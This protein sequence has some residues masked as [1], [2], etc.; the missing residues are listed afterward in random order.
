MA[1][2]PDDPRFWSERGID[3]LVRDARPYTRYRKEDVSVVQDAFDHVS[4]P[5][6]KATNTR[7]A[8]KADGLLIIKHPALPGLPTVDPQL[9]PDDAI[10]NA[11]P[12][13]HWHGDG[14]RPDGDDF[15]LLNP[16]SIPGQNHLW[17]WHTQPY[18]ET[19]KE[20]KAAR[21]RGE[22]PDN[23]Q[24][25]H[26]TESPGKYHFSPLPRKDV[27]KYHDHATQWTDDKP[28]KSEYVRRY[29]AEEKKQRHLRR[30]HTT[31]DAA[32][33]EIVVDPKGRHKH[34][35][36]KEDK[37]SNPPTR[38]DVHPWAAALLDDAEEV[39]FSI[40][41]T[42][43]GDSVLSAI[44]REGRKAS[45]VDVPS[46][47]L[48][49]APELD[50]FIYLKLRGKRTIILPDADWV[51]NPLVIEQARLLR[52]YL[53]RRGVPDT[54]VAA[55]PVSGLP[56]IKGADDF[57]GL[58]GGTLDGVMVQ[59]R[60]I[61]DGKQRSWLGGFGLRTDRF[62]RDAETLY[63]LAAHAGPNGE[64]HGTLAALARVLDVNPTRVERAIKSLEKLGGISLSGSLEIRKLFFTRGYGWQSGENPTITLIEPL[65]GG[66]KEF[67]LGEVGKHAIPEVQ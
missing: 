1:L 67:P 25:I 54:Y 41:G 48:W 18:G 66:D 38:I 9:R 6:V 24:H 23:V 22:K 5:G 52:S 14:K 43:K 60:I 55:P 46:V 15:G 4:S 42:M 61:Y 33:N 8:R 49:N 35:Y 11:R 53:R 44:M 56:A 64:F 21:E 51:H 3:P 26:E 13:R 32:G 31:R 29:T 12:S 63:S 2:T 50:E 28:G 30:Q 7:K 10:T 65:R 58:G 17:K 47:T 39:F 34:V 16:N 27:V 45:V 62:R 59:H 57:L 20:N 36:R 37:E 19:T 40:E